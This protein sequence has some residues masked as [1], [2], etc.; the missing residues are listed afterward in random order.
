MSL[1][2]T[3]LHNKEKWLSMIWL[4]LFLLAVSKFWWYSFSFLSTLHHLLWF[5]IMLTFYFYH[6]ICVKIALVGTTVQENKCVLNSFFMEIKL[7]LRMI[8]KILEILMKA[9]LRLKLIGIINI[10]WEIGSQDLTWIA[11]LILWLSVFSDLSNSSV[12]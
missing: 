12:Y 1:S 2:M 10:V 9:F 3:L 6:N 5:I 11:K 4:E 7:C 8:L